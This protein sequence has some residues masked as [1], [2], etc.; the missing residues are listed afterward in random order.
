MA[1]KKIRN[2]T[3]ESQIVTIQVSAQPKPKRTP[4]ARA[5]QIIQRGKTHLVRL[6]SGRDE[7]GKRKYTNK[8]IKTGRKNAEKY[9]T[10]ALRDKDLGIFVE[11]S[12]ETVSTFLTRWLKTTA[13]SRVSERTLDGYESILTYTKKDL[14]A[15]RLSALRATDIQT[16]YSKL[17]ASN[18]RH[19]HAPLRSA[20]NQAVRENLIHSNPALSVTL[21]RHRAKEM[22]AFSKAEAICLMAVERFTRKEGDRQVVVENKYRALFAFLLTTGA[23]PSEAF[24]IRWSDL[25]LDRATA[26]ITRTLQWHKGKG[27]GFYFAEPKTKG[28]RRIV[29]LPAG[30]IAQLREHRSAQAKALLKLGI[31]TDLLFSNSQGL[32][33]MRSNLIKRHYKP[34]LLAA[35]LRTD[36]RL[37]D[38]RHTCATLLLLGGINPKVVSERLGHASIQ[39]TMD[40]YSHVLPGMQEEATA[41]LDHMLYG[42]GAP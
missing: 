24:A 1:E 38:L 4:P 19:L 23:R 40:V 33:L 25:D 29:P 36:A 2:E 18:A 35:G 11:P 16:C 9:L 30:L 22:I 20:L 26:S 37:Y 14:G 31:R 6:Y 27:K 39:L 3:S 8:T 41:Q 5:G 13:K 17:T 28:S 32:P 34:A 7:N 15:I 21:P 10:K 42:S 12:T